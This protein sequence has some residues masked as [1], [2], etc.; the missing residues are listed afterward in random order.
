VSEG[1]VPWF[2]LRPRLFSWKWD[3]D[4]KLA[5]GEKNH[6][7]R[8][9]GIVIV[10]WTVFGL[11]LLATA[12]WLWHVFPFFTVM[13]ALIG[14]VALITAFGQWRENRGLRVRS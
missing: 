13:V 14:L 1:G 7:R 8:W 5:I 11:A 6:V 9:P 2:S 10:G 4:R 12:I 3:P